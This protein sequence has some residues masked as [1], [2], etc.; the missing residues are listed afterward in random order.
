MSKAEFERSMVLVGQ[1]MKLRIVMVLVVTL[2][3]GEN[4]YIAYTSTAHD[5][6]HTL[7]IV[8]IFVGLLLLIGFSFTVRQMLRLLLDD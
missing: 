7:A 5:H 1:V 3:L 2:L 8:C 4:A 6:R